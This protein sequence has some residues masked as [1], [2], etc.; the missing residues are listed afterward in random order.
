MQPGLRL[1]AGEV[2][3]RT[4]KGRHTT[5]AADL[6]PLAGGGYVADTPGLKELGLWEIAPDA[7]ADLFPELRDRPPCRYT[8]CRH[9]TE[10]GCAVLAALADGRLSPRRYESF[11]KLREELIER[12]GPGW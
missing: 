3:A 12:A 7:L 4:G 2:N 5:T 10:P 6:L 1:R 8:D 11:L 9:R